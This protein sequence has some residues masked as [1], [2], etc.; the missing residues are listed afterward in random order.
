[1]LTAA[2]SQVDYEESRRNQERKKP[3]CIFDAFVS[4]VVPRDPWF[5]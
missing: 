2:V 3:W 1:V 5:P 4:F